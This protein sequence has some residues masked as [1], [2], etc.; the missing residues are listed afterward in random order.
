MAVVFAQVRIVT[1]LCVYWDEIFLSENAEAPEA[2]M[3]PLEA[4]VRRI[5]FPRLFEARTFIRGE[6]SRNISITNQ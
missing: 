6:S 1:N 3:T 4:E 2:R 5:T